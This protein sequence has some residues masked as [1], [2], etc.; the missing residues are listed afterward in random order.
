MHSKRVVV[1]SDSNLAF[2][3]L[4]SF[5]SLAM[6][7]LFCQCNYSLGYAESTNRISIISIIKILFTNIAYTKNQVVIRD[8]FSSFVFRHDLS[9]RRIKYPF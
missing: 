2:R 9:V 4:R 3:L 7:L 1:A 5:H 6:T 8:S